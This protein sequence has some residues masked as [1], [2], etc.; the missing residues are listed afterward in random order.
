MSRQEF[1]SAFGLDA[2]LWTT[3]H[4][5]A[6]GSRDIVDPIQG[7]PGFLESRRVVNADWRVFFEDAIVD[8]SRQTR[9]RF[10]TP[11]GALSMLMAMRGTPPGYWNR[12][13]NKSATSTCSA[14]T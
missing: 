1:F 6:S 14:L 4:R 12:L 5:P 11:G 8:G 10:V 9:Y 13:S 2:I 7:E 3:P